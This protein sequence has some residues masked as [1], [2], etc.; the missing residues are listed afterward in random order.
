M[1][2]GL[3]IERGWKIRHVEFV[4]R[5][6]IIQAS[7]SQEPMTYIPAHQSSDGKAKVVYESKDCRTQKTFDGIDCHPPENGGM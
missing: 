6:R 2:F 5:R 3:T 7:F 4:H 1:R